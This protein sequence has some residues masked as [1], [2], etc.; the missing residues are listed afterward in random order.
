MIKENVIIF[1]TCWS[2][3]PNRTGT[4]LIC[5]KNMDGSRSFKCINKLNVSLSHKEK[6]EGIK[7]LERQKKYHMSRLNN[8]IASLRPEHLNKVICIC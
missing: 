8:P 5:T 2:K 4:V 3:F 1:K 6:T 7:R